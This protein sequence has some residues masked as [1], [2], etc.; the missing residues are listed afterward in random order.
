MLDYRSVASLLIW[1]QQPLPFLF[2]GGG[3]KIW[4]ATLQGTITYPTLGKGSSS[5]Q[6]CWLGWGYSLLGGS[7]HLVRC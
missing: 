6:K 2:K 4:L 3:G 7:S 1:F 5:T